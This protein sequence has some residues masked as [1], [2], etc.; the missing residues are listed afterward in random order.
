MNANPSA[1]KSVLNSP[2]PPDDWL[3]WTEY[4]Y[5]W[6]CAIPGGMHVKV[7]MTNNPDR[8]AAE[9]RTNSPFRATR[10]LICQ[11]PSRDVAGRLEQAI[12]AAFKAWRVRGEWIRVDA[13]RLDA[14]VSACTKIARQEVSPGVWFREHK[15][16]K[17]N[18]EKYGRGRRGR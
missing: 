5:L 17:K 10:H 14:F 16:R 8:R 4:V 9:F 11:C 2:H 15:P 12:L 3:P 1:G 13:R 18:G 7:G 6:A